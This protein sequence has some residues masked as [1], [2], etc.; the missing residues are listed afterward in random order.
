MLFLIKSNSECLS[1]A[2]KEAKA[3]LVLLI[4]FVSCEEKD[5]YY[6]FL[7]G[8]VGFSLAATQ[9]CKRSQCMQWRQANHFFRV[10]SFFESGGITKCLMTG[11]KGNSE[12]PLYLNVE[13]LKETKLTVSLV[14]SH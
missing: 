14:A 2:L 6:D 13:G 11:H 10:F 9:F 8:L 1:Q 3:T 12:F 4:F 5:C 7:I